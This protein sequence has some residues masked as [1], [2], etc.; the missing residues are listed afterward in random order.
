MEEDTF[1]TWWVSFL[2]PPAGPSLGSSVLVKRGVGW[3]GRETRT[4][5]CKMQDWVF[6]LLILSPWT[7]DLRGTLTA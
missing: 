7:L 4:K 3:T 1:E 2:V 6:L 5:A